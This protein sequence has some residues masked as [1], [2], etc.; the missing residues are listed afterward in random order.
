MKDSC[1]V[2]Y[3]HLIFDATKREQQTA[4]KVERLQD[5]LNTPVSAV[6][7]GD[8]AFLVAGGK[9]RP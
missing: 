4:A 3:Q 6:R 1:L 5:E 9:G 7:D 8:V 2:V